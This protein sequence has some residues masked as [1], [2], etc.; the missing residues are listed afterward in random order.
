ML[1]WLQWWEPSFSRVKI[2]KLQCVFVLIF[3]KGTLYH[4]FILFFWEGTAL[5]L[6]LEPYCILLQI[7]K[8]ARHTFIFPG[9]M[10]VE[11]GACL[12]RVEVKKG[13]MKASQEN[14]AIICIIP[15]SCLFVATTPLLLQ[16]F[17]ICKHTVMW[18]QSSLQDRHHH[19]SSWGTG[20]INTT[21]IIIISFEAEGD[22]SS[23]TK[24]TTTARQ[25]CL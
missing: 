2:G 9:Q 20:I 25:Q 5:S 12:L 4:H 13:K 19:S 8:C 16:A 6:M 11:S 15:L 21:K 18:R 7:I 24:C 17:I 14:G 1:N 23:S 3:H 10:M 22:P